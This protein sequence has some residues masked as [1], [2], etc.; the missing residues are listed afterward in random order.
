MDISEALAII[1]G[2][3]ISPDLLEYGR[4]C[5]EYGHS[6]GRVELLIE[7]IDKEGGRGKG[8]LSLG[9]R[10]GRDQLMQEIVEG[11]NDVFKRLLGEYLARKNP[12]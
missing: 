1:K 5:I 2:L 11:G 12:A 3:P 6:T 7:E 8:V 4:R 9:I 10:V